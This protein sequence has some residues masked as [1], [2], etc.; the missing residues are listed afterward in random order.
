MAAEIRQ[1]TG[2]SRSRSGHV[3]RSYNRTPEAPSGPACLSRSTAAITQLNLYRF[4]PIDPVFVP[5]LASRDPVLSR[6]WQSEMAT[7][8]PSVH[9]GVGFHR[10]RTSRAG[11]L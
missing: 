7:C 2:V 5:L 8:V 9:L 6:R 1:A 11:R 10:S 4:H 3:V